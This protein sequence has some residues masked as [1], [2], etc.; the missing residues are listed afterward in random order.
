VP[1]DGEASGEEAGRGLAMQ[2]RCIMGTM[3]LTLKAPLKLF[4]APHHTAAAALS[5]SARAVQACITLQWSSTT[6]T[7]PL[8]GS[9]LNT[10]LLLKNAWMSSLKLAPSWSSS[11]SSEFLVR[12][13][14]QCSQDEMRCKQD[15]MQCKQEHKQCNQQHKRNT[16]CETV[17]K[18]KPCAR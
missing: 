15:E 16:K 18:K 13:E 3:S 1:G 14:M 17:T 4:C 5:L 10:V 12:S 2:W 8:R 7:R 6:T 11:D 9:R